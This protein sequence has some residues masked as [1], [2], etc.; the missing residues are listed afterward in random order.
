MREIICRSYY[1]HVKLNMDLEFE[2]R[3][4]VIQGPK[5]SI[6]NTILFLRL[7]RLCIVCASWNE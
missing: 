5:G 6:T 3:H 1:R 2:Q 4:A 7:K